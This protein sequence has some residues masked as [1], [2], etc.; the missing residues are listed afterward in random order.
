MGR[1]SGVVVEDRKVESKGHAAVPTELSPERLIE[2][3][4]LMYHSLLIIIF[5]DGYSPL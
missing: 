2:F 4:R 3:Y 1:R 5:I